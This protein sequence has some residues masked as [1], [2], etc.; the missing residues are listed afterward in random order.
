MDEE[1]VEGCELGRVGNRF[2]S[3]TRIVCSRDQDLSLMKL[4]ATSIGKL[5]SE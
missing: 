5:R 2:L 1:R 4:L 3:S